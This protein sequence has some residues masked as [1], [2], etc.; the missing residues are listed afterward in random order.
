MRAVIC[1]CGVWCNDY[2]MMASNNTM[3]G[4]LGPERTVWNEE[5]NGE[6]KKVYRKSEQNKK[7][8]KN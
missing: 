6:M 1:F 2:L 7:K 8:N 4:T 5:A 3:Y